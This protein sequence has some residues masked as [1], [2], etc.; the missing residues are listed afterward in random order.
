MIA[1]EKGH[2]LG[3]R[4]ITESSRPNSSQSSGSVSLFAHDRSRVE[5][6]ESRAAAYHIERHDLRKNITVYTHSQKYQERPL[7]DLISDAEKD[8]FLRS[9]RHWRQ[10]HVPPE[11]PP[12]E[13]FRIRMVY[14]MISDEATLFG[15]IAHRWKITRR[16][17][18]E[19][20]NGADWTETVADAWYLDFEQLALKY[21]GFSKKLV[22]H[23]MGIVTVNNERPMIEHLGQRPSGLCARTESKTIRHCWIRNGEVR[24]TE[25][26]HRYGIRSLTE[27][28]FAASLFE[29]P[30]GFRKA[31]IYPSRFTMACMDI[32]TVFERLRFSVG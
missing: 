10:R 8:R 16:E 3:I 27:E 26:S 31:P 28:L 6:L 2:I 18:R 15:C 4:V 29:V 20:T 14:E 7:F 32:K 30:D 25:E 19:H 9:G 22:H 23:G 1:L 21:S 13:K 11:Q 17:E 5:S 24:E 12:S